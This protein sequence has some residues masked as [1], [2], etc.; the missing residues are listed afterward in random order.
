MAISIQLPGEPDHAAFGKGDDAL[1]SLRTVPKPS[2][3]LFAFAGRSSFPASF[4][5]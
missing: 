4:P 2:S 1:R 5:R 3:A